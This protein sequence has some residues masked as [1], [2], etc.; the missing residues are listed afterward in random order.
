[1]TDEQAI[2]GFIVLGT[3][4][5]CLYFSPEISNFF[6]K[7]KKEKK[8]ALEKLSPKELEELREK[9]RSGFKAIFVHKF[10]GPLAIGFVVATVGLL[11]ESDALIYMGTGIHIFGWFLWM[12]EK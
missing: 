3:I 6:D 9:E 1:M 11:F 8:K 7:K 2:I 10:L 4:I 12:R 5:L